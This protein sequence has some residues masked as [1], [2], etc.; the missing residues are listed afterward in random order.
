[1][2]YTHGVY[3][4]ENDTSIV[5]PVQVDSAIQF[6]VGTAPIN[7]L[8]DP[9]A[10]VNKPMLI[11]SYDEAVEKLGFSYDYVKFSLCQSMYA[12]FQLINV[13]PIVMVNVLDPA[14][15]FTAIT[16]ESHA[17]TS[18]KITISEEGILLD[19]NFVVKNSEGTTTY[20][21]NTDYALAFDDDGR[22]VLTVLPDGDIGSAAT[23]LLSYHQLDPSQVTKEDIIGGYNSTT[24]KYTGLRCIDQVY[25]RFAVI[26]GLILAPGWSHVPDVGL[27]MIARTT[28]ISGTFKAM[29]VLDVDTTEVVEYSAAYTWKTNNSYVDANCIVCWPKCLVGSY[30]FYMSVLIAALI[31]YTDYENDGVPYVSPSNK[32]FSIT[33]TV[34]ADGTEVYLT[35]AQATYL[36]SVGIMTAINLNGWRSWGN[37]TGIYPASTD[38][39]DRWIACRRMF[40]WWG[41]TFIATYMQKVDDPM[42]QRLIES[43]V[44]SENIRANGYKAKYQIAEARIEYDSESNTTT[45]LLNGK[46]YFK[47]YFTPF[48]PAETI[49]NTLEYDASALTTA[50]ESAGE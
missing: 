44:E 6:I 35:Q 37:N 33:G 16:S 3:I 34:L 17:I 7:L 50:L 25:P 29:A 47:Q 31:A 15:H 1:M 4:Q 32:T 49:V 28:E 43:I 27:A 45:N 2:G 48:P 23:L 36:N 46:I 41:N 13:Y 22:V 39:K 26:P 24:G 19:S 40:S 21:K 5:A 14:E 10:A 11:N 8:A 42:N 38:V 9:A 20:V 18:G 30:Q 12:S